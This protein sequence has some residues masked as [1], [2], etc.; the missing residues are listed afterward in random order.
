MCH[1]VAVR[2]Q[3]TGQ[4]PAIAASAVVTTG[5]VVVWRRPGAGSQAR[6]PDAV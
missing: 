6:P 3:A 1:D 2:I 5:T 4:Q